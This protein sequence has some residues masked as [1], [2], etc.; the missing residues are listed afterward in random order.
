MAPRPCDQVKATSERTSPV[1]APAAGQ[2]VAAA[3]AGQYRHTET[4][5]EDLQSCVCLGRVF[6]RSPSRTIHRVRVTTPNPSLDGRRSAPELRACHGEFPAE[7]GP[8]RLWGPLLLERLP[9][10]WHGKLLKV[11]VCIGLVLQKKLHLRPSPCFHASAV[12]LLAHGIQGNGA[13]RVTY[14][15]FLFN[16]KLNICHC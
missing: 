7:R 12:I 5:C 14:Y 8:E 1:A 6:L 16:S 9:Y 13:G 4:R 2:H 15:L 10:N 3:S 11:R